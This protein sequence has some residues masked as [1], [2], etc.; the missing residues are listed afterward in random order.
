MSYYI[1]YKINKPSSDQKTNLNS[2]NNVMFPNIY[3]NCPFTINQGNQLKN[4][5]LSSSINE[6]DMR[7]WI[8][9]K[10]KPEHSTYSID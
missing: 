1:T 9:N 8:K 3:N 10:N 4:V 6:I 7:S 5:L 2:N